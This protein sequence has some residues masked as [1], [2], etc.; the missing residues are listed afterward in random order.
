[1]FH[2]QIILYK[3]LFRAPS[4]GFSPPKLKVLYVHMQAASGGAVYEKK[5]FCTVHIDS[6]T[7]VYKQTQGQAREKRN[8]AEASQPHF[9]FRSYCQKGTT[10]LSA[11]L[12]KEWS[13][14]NKCQ[15]LL[16]QMPLHEG[17]VERV[18]LQGSLRGF[19]A[20]SIFHQH[21]SVFI[22][23]H[24]TVKHLEEAKKQPPQQHQAWCGTGTAAKF[25]TEL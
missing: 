15:V 11:A 24:Q 19:T 1:M 5:A 4:F 2:F 21:V 20:S 10:A 17:C 22:G 16:Q 9:L 14:P 6:L 13:P 18:S 3:L 12:H 7:G 23:I 25:Y 8:S